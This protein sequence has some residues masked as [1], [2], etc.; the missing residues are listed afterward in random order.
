MSL[1]YSMF[2]LR[3]SIWLQCVVL[4]T[5]LFFPA[6]LYA[7]D[8]VSYAQQIK[9][10]VAE[11]KVYLLENIR[12]KVTR[13][14]EQTIID[15]LLSEDGPLAVSLYKKQLREYPDPEL[16]KLSASRIAAY[17][18][19]MESNDSLS[20]FPVPLPAPNQRSPNGEDTTKKIVA[21][22][23]KAASPSKRHSTN[24][25]NSTK[26]EKRVPGQETFTLQFGSFSNKENAKILAK[27]ISIHEPVEMVLHNK[28]YKV[29]LKKNY[30]STRK[31]A[32][33]AKKLPFHT[34]VVPTI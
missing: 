3:K 18:L 11:D 6:I 30:A 10:Y 31:A 33:A 1:N 16:D 26:Q 20:M 15:A 27:K 22:R 5:I 17:N 19:A 4:S 23:I 9:Q 25:E 2:H 12:Q 7:I 21:H 29:L 14:S 13:P 8:T 32:A 24:I 34:I 28:M